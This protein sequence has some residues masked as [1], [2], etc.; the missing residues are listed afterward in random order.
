MNRHSAQAQSSVGPERK[1]LPGISLL[2]PVLDGRLDF[3]PGNGSSRWHETN[4]QK[5]GKG[6]HPRRFTRVRTAIFLSEGSGLIKNSHRPLAFGAAL[7]FSFGAASPVDAVTAPTPVPRVSLGPIRIELE[8]IA[9]GVTAPNDL[10]SVADGR[11]F[12]DEQGG[13]I[14]IVDAG[15]LLASPFLDV[16]ARLVGGSDERGLLG[17]TFHPGY[18]DPLSPGFGK[19][20]TYT[21]EPIAGPADFTVPKSLPFSHQSVIAEWQVSVENPDIADPASRR[22][23]LRIDEPG[24]GHNGGKL[25]FR[26]G[27]SY[28]YISLGDGGCCHDIGDGH[29]PEIGNGQDLTTVLGKI[30]RID[31]LDPSLTTS[32][33]DPV[34]ANGHYRVPASNP[35][36]GDSA[37][38]SEIYAYGFRNPFRFS[39][40]E[41]SDRLIVADVGE[42]N[43]EEVDVVEAGGN[44]GWN[45]KE[46]SFLFN[47][48]DGSIM[49]D[50]SPD[51]AL[52]DPVA[53]YSHFD[54][55]AVIGG[56]V[57]R[58]SAVP[59]LAGMY[60]FGEYGYGGN[61]RLFYCDLDGGL[62]KELRIGNPEQDLTLFLK[63]IGEDEKGELYALGDGNS[64]GL[65]E[66][67]APVAPR[68]S[69][70]NL[71]TRLRV[72]T[73]ENVLVSG[74]I[75]TGS[76]SEEV[77]LRGLGPSLS[78]FDV[79]PAETL[80]DPV[81]ELFDSSGASIASNGGWEG[82]PQAGEISGLGLAPGQSSEAALLAKLPPGSY[83]AILS[84]AQGG[85]GIGIVELYATSPSAP[86]N[87]VN[88]STRGLV[89]TDD[90]VMIGGV[91]IGGMDASSLVI[92]ALGPSLS[93][94][95]IANA[96]LDPT[97]ELR[98]QEG[99]LIGFN[100]NWKE[101]QQPEI[102]ATGLAPANEQESTILATL[103]PAPYTAIVRGKSETTGVALVEA[104][105][106]GE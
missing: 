49:A 74:F 71:S 32:S 83:T 48:S 89:G 103:P 36:S 77:V 61:G 79:A 59:A 81:I 22:E 16:S 12:F 40:D 67:L 31:P 100:D 8:Q 82:G 50:P 51:P 78:M 39:F 101:V 91:I 94:T 87:P 46:G 14:R 6:L 65:V 11:L 26:P 35:F 13:T 4:L 33:T 25:A 23:V 85:S 57:Y 93:G 97:L 62:I 106:V 84:D 66:K 98:D 45:R 20:Y 55:V 63:G 3:F 1:S 24:T 99:D 10:I 102:E 52:V 5:M 95:G 37:T 27:E 19:L 86:A 69:I 56:Y 47:P 75:I 80:L 73:G 92:R 21:T 58:G 15:A 68:P 64:G 34:S 72:G 2:R 53:E 54:G 105:K 96:L 41:S 104:Y 60:V 43:I 70:L 28:L 30:L 29:N 88:I 42:G 38:V 17:F 18:R 9:G 90:N 76:D 7:L 44:Y